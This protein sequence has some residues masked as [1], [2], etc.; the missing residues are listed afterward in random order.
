[1]SDYSRSLVESNHNI[2]LPGGQ[3]CLAVAPSSGVSLRLARSKQA[4]GLCR[5]ARQPRGSPEWQAGGLPH[6][7]G[8]PA[9]I[10]ALTSPAL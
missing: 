2:A 9:F 8:V 5:P 1:M 4:S 6:W 10:A 3:V 7:R